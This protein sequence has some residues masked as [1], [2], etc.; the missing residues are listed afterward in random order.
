MSFIKK[1]ISFVKLFIQKRKERKV[2]KLSAK[3]QKINKQQ[4]MGLSYIDAR[5][6]TN[7]L[8]V[9]LIDDNASE[10][11]KKKVRQYTK[12]LVT[13]LTIMACVWISTSYILAAIALVM[14]GNAEPLSSLSEKVC[15]VIIGTVIAYA[16]KSLLESYSAAKHDLDVMKFKQSVDEPS[17]DEE[18][19]G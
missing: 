4:P 6:E 2:K 5:Q 11:D 7:V 15:E 12:C 18:A 13:A 14:Y 10:K 16:F 9:D 1:I 3:I 19:V 17:S 8:D